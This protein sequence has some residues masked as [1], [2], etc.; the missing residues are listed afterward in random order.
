[1]AGPRSQLISDRASIK[2]KAVWLCSPALNQCVFIHFKFCCV[3][4]IEGQKLET[5][6]FP[7]GFYTACMGRKTVVSPTYAYAL[8]FPAKGF[9]WRVLLFSKRKGRI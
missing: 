5:H 7:F 9:M 6:S 2:T 8:C 4:N 3:M 1:M